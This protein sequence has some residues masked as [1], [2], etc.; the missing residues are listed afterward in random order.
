M[1]TVD[2]AGLRGWLR[3]GGSSKRATIRKMLAI[4]EVN[5][6]GE[7][8]AVVFAESYYQ[9][10]D[11]AELVEVDYEPLDGGRRRRGGA[12]AR[13]SRRSTRSSPTT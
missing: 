3:L 1:P 11:A 9:A 2:T 13:V 7:A 6:A 4:D 8:V 5:F 12:Q 10:E